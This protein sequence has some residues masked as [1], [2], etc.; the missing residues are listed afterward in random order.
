MLKMIRASA[1]LL[2]L[3]G[4]AYAG[5]IFTPPAP[6][7]AKT[8]A[9]QESSAADASTTDASTSETTD[10]LTQIVLTAFESLLL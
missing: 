2:A 4:A 3:T 6:Q 1:L 10:T 8:N 5:E 7:P 9:V